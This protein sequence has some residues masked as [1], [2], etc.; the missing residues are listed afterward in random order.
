[1][2]QTLAARRHDVRLSGIDVLARTFEAVVFDWDGTAVPDRRADA[3]RARSLVESLCAAGVEVVVVSGTH[4]GNVDGQLGARPVGPGRLHLCLNRGSE[5]FEA[6][7]EGVPLVWRREATDDEN[8]A[9]DRAAAATVERLGARGLRAS[10]VS[11]RLNRRKIDI[12]PEP[13]WADPPKA[14]IAELLEAVNGRL[15]TVGIADLAEVVAIAIDAAKTS[16]VP[17]PRVTSDVKHVE[18]GLTDKTDSGEWAAHWLTGRGITGR[19]VLI[20]GDEFAPVGGVPGSD[21]FMVVPDLARA[22]VVS[23]G[24]EPG[25]V[26][27]GVEHAGGGPAR[28]LDI[29][30]D[31]LARRRDRR[32]PG[33]DDDPAWIL[34]LPDDAA[35]ERVAEA[36]GAVG[37]GWAG[38]RASREEDAMGAMPL[39]AVNGVYTNEAIPRLLPGP[40]WSTLTV[41][42]AGRGGRMLDLRT[43]VLARADD[44]SMFRSVR[45]VSAARPH[46]LALRAEAPPAALEVSAPFGRADPRTIERHDRGDVA[47]ARAVTPGGGGI[48][49]AARDRHGASGDRRTIERLAAWSADPAQPPAWDDALRGLDDLEHI[50]FDRLLAEHRE[51]WAQRWS[52][53]EVTI[54]GNAADELAARFAVFH[55]LNV[56]PDE[57]EAAVGARG[58]TGDGYGGHVFWD[59]DVFVLP[60][61]AAIRPAA[62]RAMIAFRIRGLPAARAAAA[63]LG[64]PGGRFPWEA[65]GDGTDVTPH[66]VTGLH[67]ETLPVLTGE[68]EEHIVADVAWAATEYAAWSGDCELIAGPARDLLVET[69]RYWAARIRCDA[70]GHGHL[71][72][73]MG[74]DEYHELV[75][76]NAYT[77]VMV[78]L[79][80]RRAA[81]LVEQTG[82]KHNG[83][84]LDEARVWRELADGLVDG[85]DP[86]RGLYEQFAGYWNLEP[87]IAEHIA[88]RPFA[89]DMLL[90]VERVAGSQLL[91]QPD[92]LMLHHLVPEEVVPESLAANLAFYEP[93]T[94]FGS[95]LSP[96]IYAALFARAGQPERALELFRMAARLDLD[97]VTGTTAGGVHLATMGGLWQALAYGFL[98]LRPSGETLNIDP[99]LPVAWQALGL[100][101]R[102]RGRRIR[103]R[104]DHRSVRVDCDEAVSVRIAGGEVRT[105]E[106]PGLEVAL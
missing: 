59:A 26:P 56:A 52:D 94:S 55:L 63:E 43:G 70:Q 92:V 20:A 15:A 40:L 96:A 12:I 65:A 77:N 6:T 3:S 8:A 41:K 5:V 1:M 7:S 22:A 54:E 51:A 89:A 101:L 66:E 76:D 53:A 46:A 14:R 84:E 80:L 81:R 102:F 69:A 83:A 93:R 73:L 16:G 74:P 50:G 24:A 37:N 62:A 49:V 13:E 79:N 31:Q 27:D 100:R 33:I 18:I 91:K 42:G 32:V 106:P 88:P 97:D 57:G 34:P 17:D 39:F 30:D 35:G 19:L 104:A 48:V 60:A 72:G 2:L 11:E 58:L 67:G 87:L 38:T 29:L 10:I 68:R 82:G 71:C 64:M 86:A 45:F 90:G 61:L 4:L 85:W 98:G 105:A 21:S 75:D 25:G 44:D 78:R 103:V 95:S 99:C 28:F 9:L 36:L 47:L 23:V